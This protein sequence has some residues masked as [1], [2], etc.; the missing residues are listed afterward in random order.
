MEDTSYLARVLKHPQFVL[1]Q[2]F[3][4]HP[5]ASLNT[6][7]KIIKN[8]LPLF[9]CVS[10]LTGNTQENL[11]S[12]FNDI[13]KNTELDEHLASKF[14]EYNKYIQTADIEFTKLAQENPAGRLNRPSQANAGF[15][16]Y[17][18]VRS[19][20]PE[21]FVETGVSAGESSTYILQA[22]HDNNF[23]K[24]YSIDVPSV[25][26]PK[27]MTTITPEGKTSGWAVPDNLKDRWELNLGKSEE[28]L[29]DILRKLEKI[30]I[31]FH[32]IMH[33]Y[34]HMMFEYTESWDFIKENG[35]L[36]SDDIVVMNGRG[37][38][39][40]IDFANLKQKQIA[41]YNVLGGIKK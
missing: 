4:L 10:R 37:H 8:N 30:D 32:D 14:V 18:L 3:I 6:S 11:K 22:M 34:E 39:P 20:K 40:F 25:F 17:M 38:S 2:N 29:P 31:F 41:I 26:V 35:L 16:L 21:F 1:N 24:L 7:K 12:F 23:G 33:S 27:G 36:L 5:F 9:D 19:I 13:S 28:L 15:F